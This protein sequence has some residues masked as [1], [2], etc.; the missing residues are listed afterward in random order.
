M[1]L[2]PTS[3]Y[4]VR[5]ITASDAD[6]VPLCEIIFTGKATGVVVEGA[7][8][9]AALRWN[10]YTLLFITNDVPFE[11]TL[12]IYLLD[13]YFHVADYAHMYFIYSTGI[14]SDLDLTNADTVHFNFLDEK[15][16]TL[17]LFPQKRF[18]VPILSTALGVH[19]PLTFFR[20]FQ[21]SAHP[22]QA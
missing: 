21:L 13:R 18:V 9:E 14:F 17:S 6:T 11:E 16:W 1:K 19:R 10:D 7:I 20:R 2:L 15:R 8:F 4:A 22:L 3:E 5:V 12:N